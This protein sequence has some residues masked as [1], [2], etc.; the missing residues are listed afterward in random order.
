MKEIEIKLLMGKAKAKVQAA[1]VAIEFA[2]L[3]YQHELARL[4]SL[5]DHSKKVFCMGTPYDKGSYSCDI[6]GKENV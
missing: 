6:C 4:Q 2:R 1:E 5:C 3:A